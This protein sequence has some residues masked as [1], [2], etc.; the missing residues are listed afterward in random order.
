MGVID[1]VRLDGRVAVVTG[2]SSGMGVAFATALAEAGA[3][4]SLP[5]AGG[6]RCGAPPPGERCG[7]RRHRPDARG[8]RRAETV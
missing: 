6:A 4:A 3:D 5:P 8:R 1:R 2:A 7:W